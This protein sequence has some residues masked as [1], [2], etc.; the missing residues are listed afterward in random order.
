VL[1]GTWRFYR[2]A[3]YMDVLGGAYGP[4]TYRWVE[5][6]GISNDQVSSLRCIRS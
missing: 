2:H 6:V 5:S 4:G 3:N 1:S